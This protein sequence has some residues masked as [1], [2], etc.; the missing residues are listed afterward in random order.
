[1]QRIKD[2]WNKG[3]LGKLILIVGPFMVICLCC[4]LCVVM[5]AAV[6]SPPRPSPTVN[7]AALKTNT[8]KTVIAAARLTDQ[9]KPT[10]TSMLTTTPSATITET[11]GPTST[12]TRTSTRTVTPS[13][14]ARPSSTVRPSAT[15]GPT[16]TSAP[17]VPVIA[18]KQPA[19]NCNPAYPDLCLTHEVDCSDLS[20]GNFRVLPPDPYRLDRDGDGLGCESN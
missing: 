16:L 1:M 8:A 10:Q 18:T 7:V 9:A 2:F 20:A 5:V 17:I 19:G 4:P 14:T 13:A 11:P 6:G 15:R 3:F 12:I